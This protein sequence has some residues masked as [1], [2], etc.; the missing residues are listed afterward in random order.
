[1][2]L[3]ENRQPGV[4]VPKL[5]VPDPCMRD[6]FACHPDEVINDFSQPF[7]LSFRRIG[8][9]RREGQGT[10]A[11]HAQDI[12]RYHGNLEQQCVDQKLP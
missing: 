7:P 8:Q 5:E 3:G 1:M 2:Q 6:H 4:L 9:Q 11:D 10:L 12:E